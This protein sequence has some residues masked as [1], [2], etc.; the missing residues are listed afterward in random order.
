MAKYS[1][2]DSWNNIH[3][4]YSRFICNGM[5]LTV[6]TTGGWQTHLGCNWLFE[7]LHFFFINRTVTIRSHSSDW[8][9]DNLIVHSDFD[10]TAVCI[11]RSTSF[12]HKIFRASAMHR[13]T[14]EILILRICSVVGKS[15][16]VSQ[17]MRILY[18]NKV[19]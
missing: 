13:L 16:K 6:T 3:F 10:F 19:D 9:L 2:I 4:P 17:N 8:Y 18:Q 11:T 1:D 5:D 14:P 7:A 15:T 12:F